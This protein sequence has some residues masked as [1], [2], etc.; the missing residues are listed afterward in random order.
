MGSK[1]MRCYTKLELG[2]QVMQKRV[3]MAQQAIAQTNETLKTAH[4]C[5]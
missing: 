4:R 3:R 2:H 5:Q 1:G